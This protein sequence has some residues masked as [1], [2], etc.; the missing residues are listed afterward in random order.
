M[1][2]REKVKNKL[3]LIKLEMGDI[4]YNFKNYFIQNI[5]KNLPINFEI[6]F[7][8]YNMHRLIYIKT[9]NLSLLKD[10]KITYPLTNEQIKIL[11]KH[12]YKVRIFLSKIL[13]ISNCFNE[14]IRGIIIFLIILN[15]SILNLIF[16]K[17]FNK[18]YIYIKDLNEDQIN[19]INN[20]DKNFKVWIEN[21]LNLNDYNLVHN[22]LNCKKK[23]IFSKFFLPELYSINEICKFLFLFFKFSILVF[24]DLVFLRFSQILIYSEIVKLCCSLSKKKKDL[25]NSYFF[26]NTN[27]FFRPLYSYALGKNVYY[28]DISINDLPIYYEKK[29]LS[30]NTN[31]KNLSWDN[32][33]LW[34]DDHKKRIQENQII[35]ASY[36]IFGP[37]SFGSSKH[38]DL[39]IKSSNS[40]LVFDSVAF[41]RTFTSS[42][43][44]YGYTYTE[45]NIIKFLKDIT[46][47][48]KDKLLYIKSK[49]NFDPKKHSKKYANYL[50]KSN[51][52]LLNHTYDAEEV[53]SK[54]D[55][56]IC[57][58]FSS[59]A[60]IAQQLDKKVCFY[61]ICGIHNDFDKLFKNIPIIRNF[62]EL[63]KW[64]KD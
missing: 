30:Y 51:F 32:Y 9:I 37:I 19:S 11:K 63:Q 24:I 25:N 55:K 27:P 33:I 58:P 44:Y 13:L 8:Q 15:K 29:D 16:F 45:N 62:T 46:K 2:N 47:I 50:E 31:V 38:F 56:I 6:F 22:N 18:K 39:N 35:N 49:R 14:V 5:F 17:K 34:N 52:N 43:N 26:F 10:K 61:D 28:F 3:A 40:I 21:K 48:D 23:F 54:F 41:R 1:R 42:H 60:Y 7:R 4:N 57:L 53:I 36:N 64:S 20:Y 12:G 59:T